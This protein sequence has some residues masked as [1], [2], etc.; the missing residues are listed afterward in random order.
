MYLPK[1]LLSFSLREASPTVIRVVEQRGGGGTPIGVMI[2]TQESEVIE[3][4][5]LWLLLL[6]LL[7]VV[8]LEA[9]MQTTTILHSLQIGT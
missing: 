2:E 4:E 3:P 9:K 8:E 5:E 1:Y 6:C 7:L